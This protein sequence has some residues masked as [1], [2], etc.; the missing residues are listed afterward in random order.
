MSNSAMVEGDHH[1]PSQDKP[2][3]NDMNWTW[4]GTWNLGSMTGEVADALERKMVKVYC[5]QEMR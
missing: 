4:F 3:K 1:S 5:V 2:P